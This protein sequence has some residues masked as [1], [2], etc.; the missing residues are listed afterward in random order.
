MK[1]L[2]PSS[3]TLLLVMGSLGHVFAA[4]FC[5]RMLGHDCCLTKASRHQHASPSGQ[6]MHAMGMNAMT[7][8]SMQMDGSDM[9]GMT[10]DDTGFPP[11]SLDNQVTQ[12]S[13]A[14][15]LVS[16]NRIEEPVDACTH[17]MSHSGT[18]NAPISSVSAPDQSNKDLGS[19]PLPVSRF[20]AR[21]VTTLARIGLPREHAPPES[22][23][24]RHILFNVFLI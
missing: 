17:C 14:D 12:L 13:S 19:I 1:R 23:A 10:M 18:Q 2:F 4:A 6:H 20:L 5:P 16:A 22:N 11:S 3:L 8:D 9:A 7:D 21:P 24:P 15:E